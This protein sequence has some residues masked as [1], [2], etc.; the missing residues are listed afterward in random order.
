M[1]RTPRAV[2]GLFLLISLIVLDSSSARADLHFPKPAADAGEVKAGTPLAHRF[3]F[4]NDGP[5]V[6]EVTR[7]H[8]GC[9][10]LTPR[11]DRRLY[12]PGERGFLLL[13]VNTLSQPA[14]AHHWKV[15]VG[16]RNGNRTQE[17]AL[18]LSARV[19]T[20]IIVEPTAMTMFAEAAVTHAILLTDLRPRPLNLV[21][22]RPSSA[23]LKARL[24]DEYRDDAG[25]VVRKVKVEI[26][27][28]YPEGRHEETV[29]LFT[30]DPTYR[31]LTVPVTIIKQ[32]RQRFGVSP[33]P[34]SL[35]GRAGQP[36]P[37]RVVLVRDREGQPVVVDDVRADHPAVHATWAAG[38]G[39]M[40]TVRITL[41]RT[42]VAAGTLQSA[43]HIRL[44]S[45]VSEVVTVPFTCTLE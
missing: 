28:D 27:N 4:V 8:T 25:H 40:A 13:E 2:L 17:I 16:V 19:V 32:P 33:N 38:P 23:R 44:Q 43:L 24:V 12:Q 15:E 35:I 6:V 26:D 18:T 34:V 3:E 22:V 7:L 36:V 1:V 10:C 31:E 14:G 30:D 37:A 20:E 9:G 29:S 21:A 11:L 5:D 39:A 42:Q 45:P 41:D